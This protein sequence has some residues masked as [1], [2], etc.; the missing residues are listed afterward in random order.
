MEGGADRLV[1][2]RKSLKERLS[3]K[4]INCCGASWGL[5]PTTISVRDN[6]DDDGEEEEV[7]PTETT[8]AGAESPPVCAAADTPTGSGM[9]LAAA[10][11]AERQYRAVQDSDGEAQSQIPAAAENSGAG[12]TPPLRVSL[13][14]LLEENDGETT[15]TAT[16]KESRAAGSEALC[17]VCM[18]RKKGAAFIP[19]GH[20]FCRV[21]SRELWLNRGSC[22]L[23]NRSILEILDIY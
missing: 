18:G 19:C 9:N 20:T 16:E 1:R 3:F 12:T 22:P 14:R 13:M 21:C 15:A 7:P 8:E 10:L 4:A 17:C 11:A 5:V 2:R 23:C 6:D